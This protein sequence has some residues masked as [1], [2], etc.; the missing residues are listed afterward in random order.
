MSPTTRALAAACAALALGL[1][2]CD[3]EPAPA[4][5]VTI[6]SIALTSNPN[7]VTTIQSSAAGP[8]FAVR[9]V[10]TLKESNGLGGTVELITGN[11]YDDATGLLIARNQF[12]EDDLV[13]FVGN[14]RVPP[15]G[16]L[17]IPQ[18]LTYVAPAKRPASAVIAVRFRDDRGNLIEPTLLVKAN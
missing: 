15:N 11:L 3:D 12:D 13:V 8:T 5:G 2:G 16:T 7:P 1:A 9:Y 17:E 10:A 6:A 14:K 4:A 18:E